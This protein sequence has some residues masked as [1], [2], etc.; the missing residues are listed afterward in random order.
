M[1]MSIKAIVAGVV[2]VFVC[3]SAAW[4]QCGGEAYAW[5]AGSFGFPSGQNYLEL[6]AGQGF[7]VAI[8]PDGSLQ[9][10]GDIDIPPAGQFLAV[11]AG[12]GHAV[13]IR[14]DRRVLHGV[15]TISAKRLFQ[16]I[17]RMPC[18][19]QLPIPAAP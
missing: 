2:G 4:G 15:T 9:K 8:R 12:F 5:P 11:S 18:S 1:S 13:A 6:A 10:F 19:L 7:I 16:Q 3:A 17:C 14:S